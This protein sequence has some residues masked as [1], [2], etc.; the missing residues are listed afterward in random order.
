MKT[1]ITISAMMLMAL[2]GLNAQKTVSA[3]VTFTG[4]DTSLQIGKNETFVVEL[5]VPNRKGYEWAIS[6]NASNVKF[7]K[8][9][10]GQAATMPGA[11]EQQL[12]FFKSTQKGLDSLVMMYKSPYTKETAE[13]KLLRITVQ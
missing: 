6:K 5:W 10:I 12:W 8:S 7:I 1:W 4:R 11:P 2:S 3:V 13:E 9:Q